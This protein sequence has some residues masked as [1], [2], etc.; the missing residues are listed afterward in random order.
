MP[1]IGLDDVK[2]HLNKTT[3]A[4]DDELA[5]FITAACAMVEDLIGHVDVVTVTSDWLPAS[6]IFNGSGFG[7][8]WSYVLFLGESPV[9]SVTTVQMLDWSGTPQ[10]V[11]A[12]GT[13]VPGWSLAGTI[14]TV[15]VASRYQVTYTSGLNPVPGNVRMAALEL[16]AHL[17]RSTQMNAKSPGPTGDLDD[18]WQQGM[19]YAL[20]F[21]VRELLGLY[22][23]TARAGD[24]VL[25]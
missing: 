5:G 13:V 7:A 23:Q 9:S 20:P 16:V 1:W 17:W 4:D 6:R 21:R 15:P 22:G 11:P 24:V 3:A 19:A 8:R 2:A 18:S 10:D 12:A 25:G 14:V